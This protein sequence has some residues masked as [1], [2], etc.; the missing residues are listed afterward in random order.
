M[1][2][3]DKYFIFLSVFLFLS[4]PHC[5]G[6]GSG[7]YVINV[8]PGSGFLILLLRSRVI[9]EAKLIHKY[10]YLEASKE[11]KSDTDPDQNFCFRDPRIRN[12]GCG[13]V[14]MKYGSGSSFSKMFWIQTLRK[15]FIL[16]DFISLSIILN[17]WQ[18]RCGSGMIFSAHDPTLKGVS[19]PG[20]KFFLYNCAFF[21]KMRI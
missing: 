13:S 3:K 2:K 11:K 4:L 14:F 9:F 21:E 15:N 17:C 18:Q 19:D 10:F 16:S 8:S 5:C 1:L 20:L 12:Q 7:W 6:F